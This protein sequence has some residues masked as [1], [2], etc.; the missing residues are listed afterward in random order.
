MSV[1]ENNKVY[2]FGFHDNGVKISKAAVPCVVSVIVQST[3]VIRGH[4]GRCRTTMRKAIMCTSACTRKHARIR[5]NARAA[6]Q[7]H[8]NRG[9]QLF[10]FPRLGLGQPKNVSLGILWAHTN[11]YA[12]TYADKQMHL[13][14]HVHTFTYT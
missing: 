7:L 4:C 5:L 9:I 3:S 12:Y 6:G 8:S 11:T 14:I 1:W 10:Y 2:I 13:P